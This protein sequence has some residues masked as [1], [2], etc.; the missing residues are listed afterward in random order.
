MIRDD[1][2]GM[3]PEVAAR[4]FEPFFTTKD[5]GQGT[6]LG[7]AVCYAIVQRHHGRIAVDSHPGSGTTFIVTLPRKHPSDA[8]SAAQQA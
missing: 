1:G 2:A 5:V 7:L 6:G 8:Q 3:P 4:I